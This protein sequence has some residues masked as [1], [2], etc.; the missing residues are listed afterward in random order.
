[1]GILIVDDSAEQRDLL[2]VILRSAG[3]GPIWQFASAH[4]L[5]H[6]LGLDGTPGIP[7]A[8][9]VVLMDVMMPGTDGLKACQR[10]RAHERLQH[11]PVIVITAKTSPA[12][13]KA[14]Y[15]AGA[16]DYIRKPVVPEELIARVSTA[17][18]LREESEARRIREH[19]LVARTAELERAMTEN[20]VLRGMLKICTKCKRV[21][22]DSGS[23]SRVED[24]LR[25][26]T[27]IT[28]DE[29]M[30]HNCMAQIHPDL[31]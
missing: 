11:L 5:N 9:D 15:T 26:H 6:H 4:A 8:N 2:E 21:Q 24:Y 3:Y 20:K 28:L 10:I 16:T 12:D 18:S 19:E 27:E 29:C 17:M 1:M 7:S 25:R 22:T 23:W 31:F 30:C 13:L 14:A